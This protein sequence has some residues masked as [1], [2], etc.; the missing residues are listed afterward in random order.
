[1]PTWNNYKV[2]RYIVQLAPWRVDKRLQLQGRLLTGDVIM[3]CFARIKV[4]LI[5]HNDV[6]IY[7]FISDL[8][9]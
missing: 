1:M 8:C 9:I 6:A 7:I 2:T 3:K 4:F 5:L